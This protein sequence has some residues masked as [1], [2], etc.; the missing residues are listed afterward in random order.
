MCRFDRSSKKKKKIQ[1]K[2][3]RDGFETNEGLD[4]RIARGSL[5]RKG[6]DGFY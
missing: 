3:R 2:K 5:G 1:K 4:T 6:V